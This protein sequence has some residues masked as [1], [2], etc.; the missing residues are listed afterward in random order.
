MGISQTDLA[1]RNVSM[2]FRSEPSWSV[3]EPLKDIGEPVWVWGEPLPSSA[4]V[5]W[6]VRK[7]YYLIGSKAD[8]K[9]PSHLLSWVR[10]SSGGGGR[11]AYAVCVCSVS[12][13]QTA[14]SETRS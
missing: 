1:L 13:D 12:L 9:L 5:G 11:C 2:F 3:L 10:G 4:A 8:A 7:Q 14:L 6:R